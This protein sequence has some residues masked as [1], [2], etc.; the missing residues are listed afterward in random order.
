MPGLSGSI[1]AAKSG[2]CSENSWKPATGS[3][4]IITESV[5]KVTIIKR[6]SPGCSGREVLF[7]E[8]TSVPSRG[9]AGTAGVDQTSAADCPGM[10]LNERLLRVPPSDTIF[11][12]PPAWPVTTRRTFIVILPYRAGRFG[13][14]IEG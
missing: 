11:D 9:R 2:T 5:A 7:S 6:V 1:A 13:T 8:I 14:E 4:L 12:F 3:M 10:F